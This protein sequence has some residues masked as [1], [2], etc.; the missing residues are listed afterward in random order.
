[1]SC[2]VGSWWRHDRAR[3]HAECWDCP[4]PTDVAAEAAWCAHAGP[5]STGRRHETTPC[6]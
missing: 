5:T 2:D 4:H 1:M 6:G 3:W